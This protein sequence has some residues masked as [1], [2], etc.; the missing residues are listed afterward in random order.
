MLLLWAHNWDSFLYQILVGGTIF[1]A[2][3][4]LPIISGDVSF[5]RRD[6]RQAIVWIIVGSVL[7]LTFLLAW[8]IYAIKG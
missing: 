5:K 8:Q 7:F 1:A 3:I 4:I 2:G 6:D